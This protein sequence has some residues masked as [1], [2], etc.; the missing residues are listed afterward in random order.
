MIS[1]EKYLELKQR[2]NK[3]H[4]EEKDLEEKF[5]HPSKKG[6]QKMQ[7]S[8]SCVRLKH[9]PTGI[10]VKVEKSRLRED[11]RFFARRLLCEKL[12]ERL[13]I[14]KSEKTIA[15]AKRKKQKKRR[16]KK[17]ILKKN[18]S[19]TDNHSEEKAT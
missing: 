9:I 4:I 10:Q 2:L 15:V 13:G 17:A 3:L 19:S 7:K 18:I 6:G 8:S 14:K 5:V 16:H 1:D 11:N 12:E